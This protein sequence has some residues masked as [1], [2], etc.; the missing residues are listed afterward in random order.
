MKQ[1]LIKLVDVILQRIESEPDKPMSEK[2][3]RTWLIDAGFPKRD[4]EAAMKLVR[5]RFE[6]WLDGR[7]AVPLPVRS[8]T[9][10]ER[11]KLRPEARD[12]LVRLERYGMIDGYEREMILERINH[13]DGEIG[14]GELDYLLSWV[15]CGSRDVESQQTIYSVLDGGPTTLH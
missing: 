11:C 13:F 12:A 1:T 14:L 2:G 8:L 9:H 15:V 3:L 10:F 5:P 6:A 4:I 7:L